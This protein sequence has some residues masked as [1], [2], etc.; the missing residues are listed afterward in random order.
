MI[1]FES[2]LPKDA[3][4]QVWL[5]WLSCSGEDE[6][7]KILQTDLST[8]G[9]QKNSRE[10]SGQLSEFKTC[11]MKKCENMNRNPYKFT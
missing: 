3:L 2:L 9:D 5:K 11:K 4:C 6:N 8:T 10:L 7:V 1:I